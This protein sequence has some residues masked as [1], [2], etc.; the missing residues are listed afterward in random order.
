MGIPPEVAHGSVRFS[1][2]RSTR[3]EEIDKAVE[4]VVAV[5]KRLGKTLAR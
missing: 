4:M 2:S 1:L 5:V 3:Q